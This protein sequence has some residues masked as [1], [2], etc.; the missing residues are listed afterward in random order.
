MKTKS[1]IATPNAR[2]IMGAHDLKQNHFKARFR[3][4][5]ECG[6]TFELVLSK[7]K[8]QILEALMKGPIYAAS[9][10]RISDIVMLL[11]RD[12]DV[13]IATDRH[14]DDTGPMTAH[15]G[16]YFLTDQVDYLGEETGEA[17]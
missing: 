9:P 12:H 11:R 2:W 6:K 17:A 13:K 4:T 8:R 15:Y 1:R 16:I 5:K 3:V 14:A 10:I 7:R